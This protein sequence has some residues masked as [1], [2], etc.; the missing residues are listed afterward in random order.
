MKTYL[1]LFLWLS[2]PCLASSP[3]IAYQKKVVASQEPALY[4]VPYARLVTGYMASLVAA[5]EP[6]QKIGEALEVP[7]AWEV[8]KVLQESYRLVCDYYGSPFLFYEEVWSVESYKQKPVSTIVVS[9]AQ[10]FLCMGTKGGKIDVFTWEE[11]ASTL[12]NLRYKQSYRPGG[13][14]EKSRRRP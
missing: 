12:P 5:W 8:E 13:G 14:S 2:L 7:S 6:S 10:D 9:D 4:E 1:F 11:R 3:R